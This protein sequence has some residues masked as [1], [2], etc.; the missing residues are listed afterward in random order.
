MTLL[1]RL[2]RPAPPSSVPTE[3]ISSSFASLPPVHVNLS[4]TPT[5][6][7]ADSFFAS[8]PD[9]SR[10]AKGP[11]FS[12]EQQLQ[13]RTVRTPD[14]QSPLEP[15]SSFP[16][17]HV[18]LQLLLRRLPAELVLPILHLASYYAV[19]VS[20]RMDRISVASPKKIRYLVTPDY[21]R[22]ARVVEVKASV[23]GM[24]QGFMVSGGMDGGYQ[25]GLE[26]VE[27]ESPRSCSHEGQG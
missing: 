23:R 11:S 20:W 16:S 9:M 19:E 25:S 12:A 14:V 26:A 5:D 13:T 3:R 24:D 18:P 15:S 4:S 1:R 22:S 10:R 7:M 2:T 21:G 8:P 6:I 17:A 27:G